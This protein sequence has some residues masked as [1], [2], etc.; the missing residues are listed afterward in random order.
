MLIPKHLYLI[1]GGLFLFACTHRSPQ[2][3][4][5]D[6]IN[7]PKNKIT[8]EIKIGDVTVT[9]KWI[10]PN[11]NLTIPN[12]AQDGYSLFNVRFKKMVGENPGKDKAMY[13]DFDMQNDFTLY[14]EG[15]SIKPAI[16][17]KIENGISG[18]YE[19]MLAFDKKFDKKDFS[20]FYRDKIFGIG[21][22]A[23]VYGQND[24]RKIPGI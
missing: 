14:C 24:I 7:D 2:Q 10:P 15:D 9:T 20:L 16:C 23:F 5:A 11:P 6:Y 21:V 8:Q 17:Q 3:R 18:N 22:L 12:I 19:Y 4:L 1:W 13:L